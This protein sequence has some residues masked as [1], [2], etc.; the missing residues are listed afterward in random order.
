MNFSF[1]V[2][3]LTFF[4]LN[5]SFCEVSIRGENSVEKKAEEDAQGRRPVSQQSSG[6]AGWRPWGRTGADTGSI[7]DKC[8]LW[9]RCSI[10]HSFVPRDAVQI[11]RLII[12]RKVCRQCRAH[13]NAPSWHNQYQNEHPTLYHMTLKL[14]PQSKMPLK[15]ATGP[16]S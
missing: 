8:V 9:A 7:R 4:H 5:L 1:S 14:A 2:S 3:F 16:V 13:G 10:P 15:L 6:G 12:Y 11:N